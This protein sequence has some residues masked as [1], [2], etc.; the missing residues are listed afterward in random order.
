MQKIKEKKHNLKKN[1]RGKITTK[2][3]NSGIKERFLPN[4]Q[5]EVNKMIAARG[6]L[7]ELLRQ[8]ALV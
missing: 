4:F 6:P 3:C 8:S 5:T 7:Q 2:I 1:M